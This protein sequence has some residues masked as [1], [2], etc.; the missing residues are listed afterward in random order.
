MDSEPEMDGVEPYTEEQISAEVQ[1]FRGVVLSACSSLGNL[2]PVTETKQAWMG[3]EPARLAAGIG[4][5]QYV[6]SNECLASLKDIKRYIQMDEQGE[7]K[8]VLEWLGEWKV[9]ERDI[10][11]IFTLGTKRLLADKQQQK[12]LSEEDRDHILKIVMMCVELFVFLTW[13]MDTES[14]EVQGR[15]TRILRSHKRAFAK[16][17]VVFSLLSIAVMYVRESHNTDRE[18]LLIKGVLYVFRNVLAI[19]DPLVSPT[20]R[21]LAQVEAHDTLIMALEK[22]LAVDFF[23]TLMSS[24]DQRRF[25]DLRPTLLDIIYYLF[26]RVPVAA[27][28]A[29][30]GP[31]FEKAARQR[32]GRHTKFGGVYAVSTE[33]GTVMP[34][35][36]V[37][38]V[39]QPFANLFQKRATV[40]RPRTMPQGP[41]DRQWRTVDPDA[42]PILRRIAAV[43]IESCFNP[44]VGAMFEDARTA[45]SIVNETIPRL[46]YVA[47]YFVDISLANPAVDLGCVCVLTRT[48][49]FGQ[50][51]QFTSS[52]LD[53]KEWAS[54][55]LA[56]YCIQQI[57]LAL[58]RMRGTKLE[59]LSTNAL[60]NLFYDGDALA[61]FV[62]LCRVF[63]PTLVS[64]EFMAQVARLADTFMATL[65]AHSESREGMYIRKR[66]N[67]AK[68]KK[69]KEADEDGPKPEGGDAELDSADE[70]AAEAAAAVDQEEAGSGSDDDDD[71]DDEAGSRTILVERAFDFAKFENAFAVGDVVSAFTHL[72]TP[73]SAIEHVYPMLHRIAVACKRPHLF[74]KRATMLRLLV[75]FDGTLEFPHRVEMLELAS[76]IFRQYLTVIDS[77]ALSNCYKAEPLNNKLALECMRAFLGR[78]LAGTSVEPVITRHIV[79]LLAEDGPGG[80]AGPAPEP[81][82]PPDDPDPE[83][84]LDLDDFDLDQYFGL[85][86]DADAAQ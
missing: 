72:L 56:M 25:K 78:S 21:G 47:G 76:W 8:L 66:V 51:M 45:T 73:P 41:V 11:P 69:P 59:S 43:F 2:E 61:L 86:G 84:D 58:G 75:L 77:P 85:G 17:E 13:S 23:L 49:T 4:A 6:P 26:Y 37:K 29:T 70:E 62:R 82:G 52:Y 60:S 40:R 54:L 80:G 28:F 19:P 48:Q 57:L 71:D 24:A 63:R 31:W 83:Q 3:G 32:A 7:G 50:V 27:L 38:E 39:L 36:D 16:R 33:P 18:A 10:I 65:K 67:K 74:F 68:S 42:I 55:S 81:A 9:L 20:S 5:M 14:D 44:L 22:E 53:L 12:V 79:N 1:R 30:D 64:L 15:F 35:F 34:V 46:L